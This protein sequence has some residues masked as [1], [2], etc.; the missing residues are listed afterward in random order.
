[1]AN[2]KSLSFFSVKCNLYFFLSLKSH[3]VLK[4]TDYRIRV[5]QMGNLVHVHFLLTFYTFRDRYM[6]MCVCVYAKF[7]HRIIHKV[8]T[9]ITYMGFESINMSYSAKEMGKI[10]S[11]EHTNIY[12]IH[13]LTGFDC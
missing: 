10:H 9:S 7:K 2:T 4:L 12:I 6:C 3:Y 13:T 11:V 5:N 1:M 8:L